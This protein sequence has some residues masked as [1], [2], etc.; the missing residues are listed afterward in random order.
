MEFQVGDVIS[1]SMLRK[2]YVYE[3]FDDDGV[4]FYVGGNRAPVDALC[5]LLLPQGAQDAK[6]S[7]GRSNRP[8]EALE[9]E[10]PPR[11]R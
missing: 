11:L 6:P 9:D 3:L 4:R 5:L 8:G 1:G 10:N 7:T 2:F